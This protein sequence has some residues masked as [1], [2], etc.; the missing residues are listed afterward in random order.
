MDLY[1]NLG[2]AYYTQ[3]EFGQAIL[4]YERAKLF[5]GNDEALERNLKLARIHIV[6]KIEPIPQLFLLEWWHILL[7]ALSIEVYAWLGVG[8]F[9]VFSLFV[10][11]EILYRGYFIKVIWTTGVIFIFVLI[12]FLSNVYISESTAYGIIIDQNVSIVSEPA[13]EGNELFILHEGTKVLI[14]RISGDWYE[15]RLAD[16]KTGWLHTWCCIKLHFR[17]YLSNQR[18]G[19]LQQI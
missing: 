10:G 12:V 15:I 6:D 14:E 19:R 18:K 5:L 3:N 2:I 13:E 9:F 4:N 8:V 11:L 16:G 1:L 17:S 7:N